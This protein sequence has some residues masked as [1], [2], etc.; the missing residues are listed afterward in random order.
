VLKWHRELVHHNWRYGR[1]NSDGR[2]RISAELEALIV[3]FG[4]ENADWGYGKLDGE[5]R[6]LGFDISEQT[7]ANILRCHGI[8]PAPQS[9]TY[10]RL[11]HH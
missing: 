8:A 10:S 9:P 4:R 7:V 11:S 1:G 5:M 3:Q 2:A 6:K